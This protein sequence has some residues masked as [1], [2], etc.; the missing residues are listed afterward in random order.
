MKRLLVIAATGCAAVGLFLTGGVAS[1][2]AAPVA[3]A[4]V[5]KIVYADLNGGIWIVKANGSGL[6]EVSTITADSVAFSPNGNTVAYTTGFGGL[7]TVPATGG[8]PRH[9]AV[10]N[11]FIDDVAWSPNGKWL[12]Y[13]A[14]SA[15]NRSDIYR[16]PAG[17][18]SVQRLTFA[19]KN[20]CADSHPAWSPDST[21][22][23]YVGVPS[24]ATS[25]DKPGL[26]VQRIGQ[27][28]K[29]VVPGP[30]MLGASF[31]PTGNLVYV[32]Q[33]KDL[34]VCGDVV[35][36]YESNAD[37]SN[38]TL[39]DGAEDSCRDGDLC[40]TAVIGAARGRGWV[41]GLDVN[42]V[43][44]GFSE[45]CFQGGYQKA[46]T[47]VKTSPSFCLMNAESVGYDVE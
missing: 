13:V 44:V 14:S 26:V 5:Q 45:T 24:G 17:G 35:V 3:T 38:R 8:A 20:G 7:W 33:C 2:N 32:T 37:G 15:T 42:P 40:Q 29:L 11:S 9:I 21:T 47:V 23:A 46:G 34:E 31:T 16:V 4:P 43:E 25:C 41:Q 22:I 18:G 19:E 1:A 30:E 27:Q 39:I 36:T 6:H 12:A 28:G 10:G